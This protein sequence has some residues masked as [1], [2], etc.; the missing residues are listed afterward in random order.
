MKYKVNLATS[1]SSECTLST[2]NV[3]PTCS[4]FTLRV[5]RS[6]QQQSKP[7]I[8]QFS[9]FHLAHKHFLTNK[10]SQS[11]NLEK[12]VS[13]LAQFLF[14]LVCFSITYTLRL[15]GYDIKNKILVSIESWCKRQRHKHFVWWC[16]IYG[17]NTC[18]IQMQLLCCQ[19]CIDWS[20]R[21]NNIDAKEGQ[22]LK[23]CLD[24]LREP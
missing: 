3:S 9:S 23:F 17:W 12:F 5:C 2:Q 21:L 19:V 14:F 7:Y 11:N 8:S 18:R 15:H 16:T 10:D 22:I 1:P 13:T 24:F 4:I 6:F 20:L